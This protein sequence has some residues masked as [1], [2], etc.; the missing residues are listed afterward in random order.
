MRFVIRLL[1]QLRIFLRSFE[2]DLLLLNRAFFGVGSFVRLLVFLERLIS[3]ID[4]D[5]II[6]V[7]FL[8]VAVDRLGLFFVFVLPFLLVYDF[9][10]VLCI[11]LVVDNRSDV[12][13]RNFLV[14]LLLAV[15]NFRGLIIVIGPCQKSPTDQSAFSLK[16][17]RRRAYSSL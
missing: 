4:D 1:I 9:D 11:F 15:R 7:V 5:E 10:L 16:G 17:N 12:G 8:F 14:L 3:S 6:L 2:Q 13:L